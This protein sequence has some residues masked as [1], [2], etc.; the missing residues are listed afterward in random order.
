MTEAA[1]SVV[2]SVSVDAKD[3]IRRTLAAQRASMECR[4]IA[5][6]RR[7]ENQHYIEEAKLLIGQWCGPWT[8]LL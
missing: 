2:R 8:P 6:E 1:G 7:L 4:Q 5:A 3:V